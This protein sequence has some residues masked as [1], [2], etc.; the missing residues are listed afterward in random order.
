MSQN[1]AQL[2]WFLGHL[3]KG[4]HYMTFPRALECRSVTDSML[5]LLADLF[6]IFFAKYRFALPRLAMY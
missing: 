6:G 5:S 1:V 3:E 4:Q 2:I